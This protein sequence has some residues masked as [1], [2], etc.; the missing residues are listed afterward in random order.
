MNKKLIAVLSAFS[1]CVSMTACSNKNNDTSKESKASSTNTSTKA[2]KNAISLLSKSSEEVETIG[3]IGTYIKLSDN[4]TTVE[5]SGVDVDGN[6]I[7]I[8]TPGTYSISGKLSDGQI[9]VNTDKE[10]KTYILLDGVDIKCKSN[11]PIQIL[12]S[13]KTVFAIADDSENK[14]SDGET[15]DK[16]ENNQEPAIFSKEE[17]IF[18]GNGYLKVN[19]NYDKGIVAKMI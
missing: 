6:I 7:N 17:L 19:G 16:A 14:I 5:G 10:K 2:N 12:I 11:S 13:E 4:N 3:N 18:I 15:Y 8:N 1:L 9:I